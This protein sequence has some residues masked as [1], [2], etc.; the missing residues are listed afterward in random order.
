MVKKKKKVIQKAGQEIGLKS[1]EAAHQHL[2]R[3]R[4]W[5]SSG[6]KKAILDAILTGAKKES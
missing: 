4:S 2:T 1:L 3:T 5:A 6:I